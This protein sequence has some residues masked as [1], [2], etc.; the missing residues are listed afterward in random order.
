MK[1][2]IECLGVAGYIATYAAIA[3]WIFYPEGWIIWQFVFAIVMVTT[4]INGLCDWM[5][6]K[7]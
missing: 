3:M 1:S 6:P 2:L 4:T 7:S 5:F